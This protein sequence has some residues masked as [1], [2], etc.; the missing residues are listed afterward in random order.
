MLILT[1]V[2]LFTDE[3][4]IDIINWLLTLNTD[5]SWYDYLH[6]WPWPLSAWHSSLLHSSNH[7]C[8]LPNDDNNSA[9]MYNFDWHLTIIQASPSQVCFSLW[10]LNTCTNK[11]LYPWM[12]SGIS[13]I[14]SSSGLT[15]VV[16]ILRW[17]YYHVDLYVNHRGWLW[18]SYFWGWS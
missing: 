11:H 10:N 1:Y 5:C 12:F 8:S 9:D 6:C 16:L 14:R 17:S 3:C 2:P 18:W 13:Q 15:N 4:Y 7:P